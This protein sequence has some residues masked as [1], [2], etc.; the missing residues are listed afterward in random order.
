M[1]PKMNSGRNHEQELKTVKKYSTKICGQEFFGFAQ[2]PIRQDH[3]TVY[4]STIGPVSSA[5][6]CC[7]A[8]WLIRVHRLKCI[9]VDNTSGYCFGRHLTENY[10]LESETIICKINYNL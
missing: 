8:D 7:N 4:H 2:T 10:N 1:P 9:T 6:K 5:L 3:L